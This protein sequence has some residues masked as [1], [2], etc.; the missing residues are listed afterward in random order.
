VIAALREYAAALEA[1]QRPDRRA[2]AA[3]Y[4]EIAPALAEC[5][6]GLDFVHE[7]A[8]QLRQSGANRAAAGEIDEHVEPL[9]P[10]GDFQILREIGR[11]G[12]GV[13]YE[14]LQLSL[15][16]RVA[17]KVLPL[18]AALDGKQL[19][20]FKNEAQAAAHLHHQHIVPV[21]GVGCERGVH[22]YAMQF[23]D[24]QTLA[25]IIGELRCL[26]EF[27]GV[28]SGKVDEAPV[29][30]RGPYTPTAELI[31]AHHSPLTTTALAAALS[32]ERSTRSPA[33]FR[34]VADLGIQ[35]AEALEHA[36]QMGIVHR[37]I[38]PANLLVDGRGQLWITD[39]GLAHIHSQAGLTMSGDL[40]GT[41]R[42]MS[43]EQALA[44]R[45]LVDHRTDLYSLGVTLYE[46]LTLQPV[47]DGRDREE[48]LRQIAFE[49]PRRPRRDHPAVPVELETIVLKAMAKNADE[50]YATAQE[51]AEDLRRYLEDKP[52]KARRP[53]PW[54]R[55]AKWT[56]RHK[57][58]VRVAAIVWVLVVAAL[59]VGTGLIWQAKNELQ[60]A[61]DRERQNLYYQRVA[62][63]EREL[64]ANNLSRAEQLLEECP[65]DLR[66]WEW[67]YL[68]RLRYKRLPPL[69]HEGDV[70][71]AVFTPDGARIASCGDG[72]FISIW[73]TQTGQQLQRFHAHDDRVYQLAYSPSGEYLAS[74]SWDGTIKLWDAGTGQELRTWKGS[75][76]KVW[77][78]A[79]SPD[80]RWLA[81]GGGG[82]SKAVGEVKVWDTVT[83]HERLTLQGDLQAVYCAA[84]SPDSR[85]LATGGADQAVRVWDVET[86]Q[87]QLTYRGHNWN[88]WSVAFSP[89]G[90]HLASVA[91]GVTQFPDQEVKIW[92]ARTGQEVRALAGHV[93]GL[94]SVAFSPDGR[95]LAS[96]GVDHTVKIWDWTTGREAL[97]LRGHLDGVYSVAFSRDGHRLLTASTDRN[98]RIWDG[99]PEDSGPSE[100]LL[101]LRGH[102]GPVTAVAFSPTDGRVL[103]SAGRQEIKVWDAWSG[104]EQD[105]LPGHGLLAFS[106]DGRWLAMRSADHPV[107]FWHLPTKKVICTAPARLGRVQTVAFSPDGRLAASAGFDFIVHL[108]DT[109]NGRQIRELPAPAWPI[110][111]VVFSPDGRH[112]ASGSAEGTVR[113]WDVTTGQEVQVLA[114]HVGRVT[115]VA[116]S[117]DGK[118]LAS[119]G[120]DRTVKVWHAEAW[121]VIRD[122][123][124]LTGGVES[125]AFSPDGRYLAWG[126][127]DATVKVT[128]WNAPTE[129]IHTLRGHTSWVTS[130][131]LSP[132]GKRIASASLDGTVRIWEL[133]RFAA[134][135]QPTAKAERG[136][137][138]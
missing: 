99:S 49:E 117:A 118:Y 30:P 22:Y 83:G 112:L 120:A 79:F 10:L 119:A 113:I 61:L 64:S 57:A 75:L 56:R 68:K 84:F 108:W 105:T 36:H 123:S 85:R 43:P 96:A 101:I 77:C 12:M 3:R 122:I 52:I 106:P 76:P 134:A 114:E 55:A 73:D 90:R 53:T 138:P 34:T 65:A 2:F 54:Q 89:D 125:V 115:S 50:R 109:T 33:F 23:I 124:D 91:G 107:T 13:V 93:G 74:G 6:D 137:G 95:R 69:R 1:G 7:A 97:A 63:A 16:R 100:E 32:T 60:T 82:E 135:A 129:E 58:V 86:G 11:G 94:L 41:L 132:D 35:A 116:F 24:G 127:T 25:A 72:H 59:A 5:L 26:A 8:P 102:R 70:L 87:E 38:K 45:V 104:R 19:Q 136:H 46:L 80:G 40:V 103:A 98:V 131:S 31:T 21:F 37:D 66:G 29:Q 47:F 42:Y 110:H 67:H 62:L 81:S 88:V 39:F 27:N 128:R 126:G 17:L 28:A 130:V 9:L 20:R 71:C 48:L 44:K 92:D 14:A 18:A 78:V 121:R 4:P 51:L 15:G 111:C 133:P